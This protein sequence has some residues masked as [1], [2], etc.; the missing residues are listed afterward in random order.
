MRGKGGCGYFYVNPKHDKTKLLRWRAALPTRPSLARLRLCPG[1][2]FCTSS[3]AGSQLPRI[4]QFVSLKHPSRDMGR[5][6]G[7]RAAQHALRH[8]APKQHSAWCQNPLNR[9]RWLCRCAHGSVLP[10]RLFYFLPLTYN[11]K[12]QITLVSSPTSPQETE[13]RPVNG[14]S[15]LCRPPTPPQTLLC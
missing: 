6:G 10:I 15:L 12:Y 8:G 7:Y 14:P 9:R 1:K 4:S 2:G 11:L 13:G 5:V 3:L